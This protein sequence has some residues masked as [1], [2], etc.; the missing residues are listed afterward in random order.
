MSS[1]LRVP[2]IPPAAAG[3]MWEMGW[4]IWRWK[5][6]MLVGCLS[7]T[8]L[9]LSFPHALQVPSPGLFHLGL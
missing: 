3:L 2:S 9:C 8:L 1:T 4:G 5:A 6:G 7:L